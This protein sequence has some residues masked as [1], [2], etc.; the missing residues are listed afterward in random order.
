MKLKS[1]TDQPMQ[2]GLLSGHCISVPPEGR[3]VPQMFIAEALKCG[4][5]PEGV[6]AEEA[7]GKAP[8]PQGA[9]RTGL[10]SAAVKKMLEDG[11]SLTGAGLPHI[12]EVSKAAGFTVSA[13]ELTEV[14]RKL[15]EEAAK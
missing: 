13:V 15:E 7:K 1:P 6:S 8:D 9:D 14:W 5:L 3:D 10:I 2:V 12:K 4:C 11:C